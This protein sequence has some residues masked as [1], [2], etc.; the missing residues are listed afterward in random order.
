MKRPVSSNDS[1][2]KSDKSGNSNKKAKTFGSAGGKHGGKTSGKQA[3][4]LKPENNESQLITTAKQK[5]NVL[6]AS[7]DKDETKQ[8]TDDLF[9]LVKGEL[10]SLARKHDTSRVIQCLVQNGNVEQRTVILEALKPFV[11]E[12]STSQ[13]AHFIVLKLLKKCCG[14]S[15]GTLPHQ[16]SKEKKNADIRTL[17]STIKSNV[18]KIATDAVG[19][20]VIE[21]M[22]QELPKQFRESLRVEL[23][24]RE[25]QVL[26]GGVSVTDSGE[27]VTLKS[28]VEKHPKSRQSLLL[29]MNDVISKMV[30]KGLSHFTYV[31]NL[32][33]EFTTE[34][35]TGARGEGNF[36]EK[37]SKRDGETLLAF[38]DSIADSAGLIVSSRSGAITIANVAAYSNAKTRKKLIKSFKGFSRSGMLHDFAYFSIMRLVMCTDDTI[39]I[40][41]SVLGE[42]L[43]STASNEASGDDEQK[44]PLL[45]IVLNPNA[46]KLLLWMIFD[47]D[48]EETSDDLTGVNKKDFDPWEIDLLQTPKICDA[49]TSKKSPTTKKSE[50]LQYLSPDIKQMLNSHVG[51]VLVAGGSA[52]R[53]LRGVAG[54]GRRS[55]GVEEDLPEIIANACACDKSLFE[56]DVSHRVLQKVLKSSEKTVESVRVLFEGKMLKEI[57]SSNRG[58]FVLAEM[59]G[60]DKVVKELKK[61]MK[62]IANRAK[63]GEKGAK[64]LLERLK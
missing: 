17:V 42:L 60:N 48:R 27:A 11:K 7:T 8:M 15:V 34:L 43:K 35:S 28:I 63:G 18:T 50:L 57:G 31:Q 47:D 33:G 25:Y 62:A 39:A 54:E 2:N 58:A 46:C 59:C 30:Q 49:P 20:R 32:M 5:W 4:P 1:K 23:Y 56:G 12:L 55:A 16:I 41:K 6:R 24:G 44:H 26:L 37:I 45:E 52:G 51:E 19:A 36:D 22:F 38:G 29:S 61:D 64:I 3:A 10:C 14:A 40:Q 9:E 21:Y 53:F 13:Y